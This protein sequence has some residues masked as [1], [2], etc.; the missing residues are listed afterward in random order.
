MELSREE[1]RNLYEVECQERLQIEVRFQKREEALQK[2]NDDLRKQ[3]AGLHHK[4]DSVLEQ[5]AQVKKRED[6]KAKFTTTKKRMIIE[7]DPES[8]EKDDSEEEER[9]S[10]RRPRRTKGDQARQQR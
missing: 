9:R 10:R 1:L 6:A 7:S 2:E 5:L 3:I 8:S 4:L